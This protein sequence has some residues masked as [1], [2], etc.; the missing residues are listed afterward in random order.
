MAQNNFELGTV[1]NKPSGG[2][3]P[4]TDLLCSLM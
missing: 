4:I 1:E 2:T 3:D